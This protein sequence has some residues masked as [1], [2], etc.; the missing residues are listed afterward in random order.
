MD[1][2]SCTSIRRSVSAI[3]VHEDYDSEYFVN[4]IALIRV[5]HCNLPSLGVRQLI[6][7]KFFSS[8]WIIVYNVR[9]NL[10]LEIALRQLNS[11]FD[12]ITHFC[13]QGEFNISHLHLRITSCLWSAWFPNKFKFNF[14][15]LSY[16]LTTMILRYIKEHSNILKFKCTACLLNT[17]QLAILEAEKSTTLNVLKFEIF[18]SWFRWVTANSVH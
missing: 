10:P 9:N 14:P 11:S 1:R 2:S 18:T 8:T 3:F 7:R 17:L 4:D 12:L 16:I 6:M 13:I 5:R 15:P